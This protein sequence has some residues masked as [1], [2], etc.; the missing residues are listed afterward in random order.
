MVGPNGA[1]PHHCCKRRFP[2]QA[3]KKKKPPARV[4]LPGWRLQ[5]KAEKGN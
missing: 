5:W 2:L 4:F 1:A 3:P